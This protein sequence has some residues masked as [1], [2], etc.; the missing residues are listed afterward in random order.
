[1]LYLRLNVQPDKMQRLMEKFKPTSTSVGLSE[2]DIIKCLENTTSEEKNTM[3][4]ILGFGVKINYIA[5][6]Q[7]ELLFYL[8][9]SNWIY[10]PNMKPH[11]ADFYTREGNFPCELKT[12]VLQLHRRKGNFSFEIKKNKNRLEIVQ[13]CFDKMILDESKVTKKNNITLG[14]KFIMQIRDPQIDWHLDYIFD[15]LYIAILIMSKWDKDQN[16]MSVNFGRKLCPKCNS[17]HYL[18]S[19]KHCQQDVLNKFLFD[20]YKLHKSFDQRFNLDRTELD[21]IKIKLS[22]PIDKSIQELITRRT[23]LETKK[24]SDA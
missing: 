16:G 14:G 5:S 3:I 24:C 20:I 19:M 18:N 4:K 23:E 11:G 2:S 6:K 1:M 10:P 12:S 21:L 7:G 9:N 13:E 17:I 8:E 22:N 15:G